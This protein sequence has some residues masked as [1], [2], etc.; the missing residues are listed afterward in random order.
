MKENEIRTP[1]NGAKIGERVMRGAQPVALV[2]QGDRKDTIS[3]EEFAEAL[4]GPG[5][6]CL[7]I[8]PHKP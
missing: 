8:P 1:R 6:Q 3:L 7:L 4:Y 5:T 2:K